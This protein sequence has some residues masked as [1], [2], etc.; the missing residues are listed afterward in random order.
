MIEI[1]A[2]LSGTSNTEGSNTTIA[3]KTYLDDNDFI[4]YKI[5][6]VEDFVIKEES[7]SVLEKGEAFRL[8]KEFCLKYK[9]KNQ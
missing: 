6:V 9:I 8:Y 5:Y 7:E 3:L 2:M 4:I 1:A